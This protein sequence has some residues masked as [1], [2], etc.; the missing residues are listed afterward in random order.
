MKKFIAL[1]SFLF[2]LGTLTGCVSHV[3]YPGDK[4]PS[5]VDDIAGE[6]V[7]LISKDDDGDTQAFCTGIWVSHD[8]IL[9]A[10]HCAVGAARMNAGV[11]EGVPIEAKG[12]NVT[13]II[14]SESTGIWETPKATH[15]A[16]VTALTLETDVAI[17]QAISV[18]PSH[19][20]AQ[21]ALR[22]PAVGEPLHLMGHTRGIYWTYMPGVVAGFH[23][24]IRYVEKSGPF[25]QVTAPIAGGMS[26]GGAFDVDGHLV[27]MV[28]F[29]APRA[30]SVGFLIHVDT[31]REFLKKNHVIK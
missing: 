19:V 18:V 15:V 23:A 7:A 3:R 26:G 21:L 1:F 9:T 12:T 28:S 22:V 8:T 6:T 30:P 2:I 10:A 25:I 17:L 4:S 11:D 20:S 31:I 24:H 27:G 13:Y 29:T 16:I 14:Q 5:V